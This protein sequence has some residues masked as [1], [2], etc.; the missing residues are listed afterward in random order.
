MKITRVYRFAASHRLH[1]PA[2]NDAEN[3]TLYGKCNNP[4]GH[5]HDYVLHVAVRG[6]PDPATGRVVNIG[7]LDEYVHENILSIYDHSYLNF[8]VPEFTAV[9]TTENLAAETDRRLRVSW[10]FRPAVLDGVF[11]QETDRNSVELK[12]DQSMTHLRQ[13]HEKS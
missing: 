11:I 3:A 10:P 7:A 6:Q 9:P 12:T 13:E 4:F 1:S 2:L 5:G 8:D